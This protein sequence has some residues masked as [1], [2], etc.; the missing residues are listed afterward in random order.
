MKRLLLLLLIIS[1]NLF[2]KNILLFNSYSPTSTWTKE[3]THSIIETLKKDNNAKIFVEFMDSKVFK[4]NKNNEKNIYNYLKNK[5]ANIN[6]D[7]VV[8]TDDNALNFTRKYNDELFNNAKV[9]FSG[10]NNLEL[11]NTLDKNRYAGVFEKKNPLKNYKLAK[12]IVGE[13]KTVYLIA[14][15]SV[16][17]KKEIEHY[18]NELKDIH[19]VNFIYISDKNIDKV[20]TLLNNYEENSVMFLLVFTGFFKDKKHIYHDKVT[21]LLSKKYNNPMF[22]HTNIYINNKDTNIIGGYC[23]DGKTSGYKVANCVLE[24][25]KNNDMSKLGFKLDAGN[26]TYINVENLKKY[27]IEKSQLKKYNPIYVNDTTSYLELHRNEIFVVILIF[28]IILLF[29]YILTKKNRAL[30]NVTN[31]YAILNDSLQD[32]IKYALS[33]LEEQN[34]IHEKE[35]I[36]NTKFSTIGKM[37]A[38]ITHEINTPLTYIKGTVEMSRF[39]ILDLPD[40]KQKNQLLDDNKSVIDGIKR[41]ELTIDA[42]KEM[43]KNTTTNKEDTNIYNTIVTVL[44]MLHNRIQHISDVYINKELFEFEKTSLDKFVFNAFVNKQKIEQVWAI[45]LNNALDELVKKESY[46]NRRIDI[47]IYEKDVIISV[48]ICDNA[49]GIHDNIIDEIFEPFVSAKDSSGIGIGLNVAQKIIHQHDS[50]ITAKN[51]KFGA[52]FKV[53]LKKVI[54]V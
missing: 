52:C 44:R 1:I 38:G 22:I 7:I 16:T 6:I 54:K 35:N 53:E 28:I 32:K 18:K 10:I 33:K 25:L 9:F 37:S 24:Y 27:N 3:Q 26:R 46:E 23:S 20:L 15:D 4:P 30:Q 19:E 36:K 14:D 42:M 49:G 41:I 43:V 29:L 39:D 13:I 51:K 12:D 5:Y 47:F 8:T 48:K 40:S 17:A 50:Q 34:L 21:R 31:N 45:I 11:I 2:A